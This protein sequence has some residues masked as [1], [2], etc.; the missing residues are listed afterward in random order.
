MRPISIAA[1]ALASTLS[2]TS[3]GAQQAAPP[4]QHQHGQTAKPGSTSTTPPAR[5]QMDQD[6]MMADMMAQMKAADT[7]LN[8]LAQKMNAAQ[9]DE[10][11][12]A[13]QEVVNELVKTQVSMHQHMAMMHEHMMSQM[14]HK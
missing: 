7:R 4:A 10:K 8:D 3:V 6:K 9:G 12:R 2:F 11:V 13:I 5:G 1:V 14:P